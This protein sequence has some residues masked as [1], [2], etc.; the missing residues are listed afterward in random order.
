MT[1]PLPPPS[2]MSATAHFQVIHVAS[3]RTVSIVSAGWKRMPPLLGPR[4]S[5]CWTRKPWKTRMRAVVHAHRDAEVELAHRP[6]QDR[7]NA[8]VQVE[9]FGDMVELPLCHFKSIELC[10]GSCLLQTALSVGRLARSCGWEPV[11]HHRS[12]PKRGDS[13]PLRRLCNMFSQA[14]GGPCGTLRGMPEDDADVLKRGSW[15]A[16]RVRSRPWCGDTRPSSGLRRPDHRIGRGRPGPGP[17]GVRPGVVQPR[18]VRPA[19]PLLDVAVPHRPQ[20]GHRPPAAEA[21]ARDLARRSARTTRATRCAS[22]LPTTA[23]IRPGTWRTGSWPS[24]LSREIDRAASRRT[25]SSWSCATSSDSSYN[26]IAELKNLPLGT[27]KNK[28]FRAHSVLRE[29]LEP[30]LAGVGAKG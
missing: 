22:I 30:F 4:A 25:A 3:A 1:P 10:H 15:P 16:T 11:G 19:L 8:G 9:L 26:E 5:L 13:T 24:A 17:G 20:P 18:P 28:L 12:S 14:V 27:V 23:G 2:G 7:A 6:A 29:T 21:A